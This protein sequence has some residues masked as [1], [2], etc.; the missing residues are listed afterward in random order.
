MPA[1]IRDTPI[2]K[3]ALPWALVTALAGGWAALFLVD[4]SWAPNANEKPPGDELAARGPA[5]PAPPPAAERVP[6][7]DDSLPAGEAP[8][9]AAIVPIPVPAELSVD[10][11]PPANPVAVTEPAAPLPGQDLANPAEA[12]GASPQN[13]TS[14]GVASPMP[15]G[16]APPP[17]N[18][19]AVPVPSP[20]PATG[21]IPPAA[22]STAPQP[23]LHVVTATGPLLTNDG[24][25]DDWF[26]LLPM[27][28]PAG[29][30]TL[31]VP[32]PFEAEFDI[33]GSGL[34]IELLGGT[35]VNTLGRSDAANLG[36]EVARGR[37]RL[38]ARDAEASPPPFG[39]RLGTRLYRIELLTDDTQ[40]GI[41]VVPRQPTAVG[42]DLRGRTPDGTVYV[43]AG[44]ARVAD[45]AGRVKS[46]SA[47]G[48]ILLS[49]GDGAT[50]P[51]AAANAEPAPGAPPDASPTPPA[52]PLAGTPDWLVRREP[53]PS[54]R[55]IAA[56]FARE[57]QAGIPVAQS[58]LPAVRDKRY[59]IAE[60]GVKTLAL[61]GNVQGLVKA[62][63]DSTEQEEAILA[64][65]D[66][67]RSWLGEDPQHGPQLADALTAVY[68]AA[69]AA[70]LQ[71]LLWGFRPADARD[72]ATAR[73]LV[74]W[75]E[76]PELSIRELASSDIL[77]LSGRKMNYRPTAPPSQRDQAVKRWR[78]F[79]NQ[80]GGLTGPQ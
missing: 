64:A 57:F 50:D 10:P 31:A 32:E 39:I 62:L 22:I 54:A 16:P 63:K 55:S 8:A 18:A 13:P 7:T 74:D 19:A 41:E 12:G 58:L 25:T 40:L 71:R 28:D 46:V 42:E 5:R 80:H 49:A 35:R 9:V 44:T 78:D 75:L 20:A 60:Y 68:P 33:A 4:N 47:G 61:T 27:S 52:A 76:S 73:Q 1:Y 38:A 15:S 45:E 51:A 21:A 37:L 79:I 11:A 23:P 48:T 36:L 65:A 56:E 2:W 77:R 29:G 72:P 34:K 69:T 14:D 6:P 70:S 26:E 24:R 17:A 43:T 30:V 53:T 59:F 67:I 3:R 66:G